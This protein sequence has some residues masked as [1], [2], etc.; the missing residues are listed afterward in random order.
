MATEVKD[1]EN[2][3]IEAPDEEE[4]AKPPDV[5]ED[6]EGGI[7]VRE[8]VRKPRKER[9]DDRQSSEIDRL[10]QENADFR[11][12]QALLEQRVAQGFSQ[13]E[14]QIQVADAD[15]YQARKQ[16]VIDEQESI[17]T[18]LRSGAVT[19]E[20][21]ADKLK[22]R[23]Y[24]LNDDMDNLREERIV[25][26]ARHASRQDSQPQNG[27]AEEAILRS[28]FP[29]VVPQQGMQPT[30]QQQQALRWAMGEYQRLTA[31]GEP[32]TIATSKRALQAAAEEFG[33]RRAPAPR[34]SAAQQQRYGAVPAQAGVAS[35][36][37]M[38]L[39]TAEQRMAQARW[40]ELEPKAAF[41]MMAKLLRDAQKDEQQTSE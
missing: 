33:L 18:L 10:R 5:E 3:E 8:H 17:Q 13:V 41:A 6:G 32:A 7:V 21:A 11:N 9:R 26:R 19:T 1:Q 30:I 25:Q 4:K 37:E 35:S 22:K 34:V 40:P 36:H 38:R 29:E 15:P 28:E 31:K 20:A 27:A 16:A 24:Q 12:R 2:E 39:N 14:R 23:F